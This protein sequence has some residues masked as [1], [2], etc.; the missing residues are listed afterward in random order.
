MDSRMK[1]VLRD[2]AL[3]AATIAAAVLL[4]SQ[5]PGLYQ[6]WRGVGRSGDFSKHIVNQPQRLTLYGTTTCPA[7]IS[8]RD[9]LRAAGIPFNDQLV[10][11]S[12]AAKRMYSTL[13]ERSVPLLVSSNKVLVGF[14]REAYADMASQTR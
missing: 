1:K 3:M 2:T 6:K 10:D 4:G 13:G 14:N 11:K 8:A 7:C 9:Y 5:A 12:D